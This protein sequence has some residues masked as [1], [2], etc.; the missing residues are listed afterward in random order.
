MNF[1]N[2]CKIFRDPIHGNIK[3]SQFELAIINTKIF[4]RLRYLKQTPSVSYVF[5]SANHTR[6]EHSIGALQIA[7]LYARTL[8]ID[9]PKKELLRLSALLHDIGHGIFSHIYDDTVYQEI[10]NEKGGHDIH[11]IKIIKQYLPQILMEYYTTDEITTY[12]KLSGF[13]HYVNEDI[14]TS[15]E[16][17]LNDVSEILINKG[18]IEYNII[19]GPFGCDKM[20][21]IKR[22]SYFSGTQHY[23]GFPIDRIIEYS[24]IIKDN[25]NEILCYSSKILDDIILF[26]INRFHMFKNIYFHKTC[27]AVDLMYYQILKHSMKTLNLI[28]RT[29]NI[30]KFTNLTELNFFTEILTKYTDLRNE[31]IEK[32]V[33]KDTCIEDI[34]D[35]I[36]DF[37]QE[38]IEY[39]KCLSELKIKEEFRSEMKEILLEFKNIHKASILV[40][41]ILSRDLY[42]LVIEDIFAYFEEIKHSGELVAENSI[43]KRKKQL[44][45]IYEE[46]NEDNCP[47][48]FTDTPYEIT[49]SPVLEMDESKIDIFDTEEKNRMKYS[50]I[51]REKSMKKW[52]LQSYNITRIYTDSNKSKEKLKP[53]ID[54]IKEDHLSRTNKGY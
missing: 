11:R 28:E 48:L 39:E 4:Q 20:D 34:T 25:G 5:N 44:K 41:R 19:H 16:A 14:R 3:I 32:S 42:K 22:D 26:L 24:L 33:S 36:D 18:T 12:L 21:F 15:I 23:A 6:F 49:M 17:I 9:S 30:E 10:Y 37:F 50:D 2:N 1:N 7:E 38:K 52:D 51:E 29:N 8:Q 47:I 35:K 45:T 53:Y 13:Q 43:K 40:Q 31:V 54:K 27:R 46:D